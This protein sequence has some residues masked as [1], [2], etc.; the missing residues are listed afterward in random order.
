MDINIGDFDF[1]TIRLIN[2]AGQ[3][4]EYNLEAELKVNENTLL[5]DMLEQ[6]AKFVYWA[7]ILEKLKYFQESKELEQEKIIAQLDTAARENC[8]KDGTKPTKDLVETYRKSQ[9][10][11]ASIMQEIHYFN[12]IV[13]RVTRIVKAFEQRKDMLQSYGKQVAEQK[14]YGQGAGTRIEDYDYSRLNGGA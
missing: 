6:P 9:P 12:F 3:Y 13:G 1:G 10:E 7:S 5:K 8:K 2:E 11:Y 4:E 14:M